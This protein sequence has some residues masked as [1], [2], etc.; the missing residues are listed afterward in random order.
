MIK[1]PC[2]VCNYQMD[3]APA[4]WRYCPSCGTEFGY[5]DA[6]RTYEQLRTEWIAG[7]MLW[8]SPTRNAPLGWDPWRQVSV[9]FRP[10]LTSDSFGPTRAFELYGTLVPR[11]VAA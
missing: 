6:G 8:W 10:S 9:F 2:P 3:Q 4:D 7:G 11:N 1:F 5:H